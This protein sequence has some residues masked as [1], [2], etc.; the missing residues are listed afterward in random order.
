MDCS[1]FPEL[2][3]SSKRRLSPVYSAPR[4]AEPRRRQISRASR[5]GHAGDPWGSSTGNVLVRGQQKFIAE[6]TDVH[7]HT[8]LNF[9]FLVE[10]GFHHVDQA[11]LKLL[12]S[13]DPSALASQSAGITGMSHC[14]WPRCLLLLR[15]E[16]ESRSSIR[17]EC[18]SAI[19]A[20]CNFCLPGSSDSLTSPSQSLTLLPRLE[21]SDTISAHCNLHFLDSNNRKI[22]V[23]GTKEPIE[24]KSNQWFGATVKA[25]K[26]KVVACAP[27]YHWRT[28]KPTP[29]KDPV[30]TCY[31][32]IQNF[33]A[34]AEFSPCRNR[35]YS[36]TQAGKQWCDHG[37]MWP[38]LPGLKKSSHLS[39]PKRGFCHVVQ[40][41]LELLSSSDSSTLA[42]Q[43]AGITGMCHHTWLEHFNSDGFWEYNKEQG[44]KSPLSKELALDSKHIES[45][46]VTRLECSGTISAYCNSA[47]WVQ[48]ILLSQSPKWSFA[49]VTQPGVQRCD[50]GSLQPP[51]PRFK[52]FFCLS[53]LNRWDYTC[54]PSCP[55]NFCIFETGFYHVGQAHLMIRPPW[56]PKG[57]GL[58]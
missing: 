6:T 28:L 58:Q 24:F 41:G 53:L 44:E 48:A 42:S 49:L 47:S 37:S 29:E 46:F 51:P 35:S 56:P 20:H 8:Q 18:N 43:S 22:R 3:T 21:Y 30:G 5:K 15:P 40:A 52:Q 38:Q 31:V 50:L 1:D 9:V 57:L 14:T 2:Q 13:S 32:A 39:L 34:Y 26:G 55:A 12:A 33:S 54:L 4:A 10:T 19:L 11:G 7:Y 25:H 16:T 23:N 45:H 36:V 17:L 27:L